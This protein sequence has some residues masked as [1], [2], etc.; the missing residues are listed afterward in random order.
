MGRIAPDSGRWVGSA[1]WRGAACAAGRAEGG[2]ANRDSVTG[3]G[4]GADGTG[5]AAGLA[6]TGSTWAGAACGCSTGA[7]SDFCAATGGIAGVAEGAGMG[8]A[9]WGAPVGCAGAD[10]TAGAARDGSGAANR[11]AVVGAV[12]LGSGGFG[13]PWPAGC[14]TLSAAGAAFRSGVAGVPAIVPWSAS[15]SSMSRG[16]AGAT[17]VAAFACFR[18]RPPRRPRRRLPV[19]ASAAAGFVGLA[20]A[21]RASP[22]GVASLMGAGADVAVDVAAGAGCGAGCCARTEGSACAGRASLLRVS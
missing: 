3:S 6:C 11:G 12:T 17:P 10:V 21:G 18:R 5:A 16:A 13:W 19:P 7:G 4:L 14:E 20:P 2:A 8:T 22:V 15:S 1:G 9:P